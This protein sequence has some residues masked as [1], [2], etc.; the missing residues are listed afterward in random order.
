MDTLQLQSFVMVVEM[1]SLSDAARK[2]GVTPAAVG[3]RIKALEQELGVPLVKRTG[4]FVKPTLAGTNILERS[5]SALRDLRDLRTAANSGAST[6]ELRL[7]VFPTAMTS[8]LPPVLKRLYTKQ[9][10]LKILVTSGTSIELCRKVDD[11]TLDAAIVV[12][13]QFLLPKSCDWRVLVEEPLVLA[14]PRELASGDAHEILRTQPF[15]RYDRTLLG[16]QLAE[17]YLQEHSIDPHERLELDSVLAIAALVDQR[18]GVA[19]LP[20]WAPLWGMGMDI[21][22]IDLPHRPPTRRV[23]L[24]WAVHGSR[25]PLAQA[26]FAEAKAVFSE[27]SERRPSKSNRPH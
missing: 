2:L 26:F 8:L 15:I 5:R 25:V 18:L 7:G 24:I 13:P 19:L 21:A 27:P 23:G 4:R 1:G 14:V 12:E 3:A 17:R 10:D 20:D 6:S 16:G 9:P 22:R 11:G